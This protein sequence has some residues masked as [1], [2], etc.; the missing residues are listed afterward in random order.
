MATRPALDLNFRAEA[1]PDCGERRADIPGLPVAIPDDFNWQARDF[2]SFRQFMLEDLGA[3]DPERQRWTEADMELVIV[4]V[5]AAGLDRASHSLD[6][7]FAERFPQTAR[8]PQ[9]LINL[10]KLI[11]GVDTAWLAVREQLVDQ[12]REK[13]GFDHANTQSD[14]LSSLHSALVARPQLM[15]VARGAG[16]NNLN[17]IISF[18]T[19]SDLEGFLQSC[20]IISQVAVQFL[21]DASG[22]VYDVVCLLSQSTMRLYDLVGELGLDEDIFFQFFDQERTRS[23]P[24][25]QNVHALLLMTEATL[26]VTSIRTALTRLVTPLLPI[27]TKLRLR[28]GTRVGIFLRL[29]VHVEN[30]F[31]RSEVELAVRKL[32]SSDDDQFFDP[33]K[34]GFGTSINLSDLQ[35]ALMDLDGVKG[36]IIN[37]AQ[38]VGRPDTDATLSGVLSPGKNEALSLDAANPSSETG[39]VILKVSGGQLG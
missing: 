38:I 4:E 37:R 29:C 5:L 30:N 35:A 21:P 11:D 3:Y 14:R 17:Q 27:G 31:F 1:C 34:L 22:G 28:D 8:L 20:P 9:S 16:L 39:Y 10:L 7:I 24:T 15:P 23:I 32:L 6:A 33:S 13:Y 12:E 18:I 25:G 19:L 2:E 36:V 26:S